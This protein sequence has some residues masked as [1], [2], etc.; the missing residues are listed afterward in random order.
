MQH[1][2]QDLTT[3][4]EDLDGQVSTLKKDKHQLLCKVRY[5]SN[6]CNEANQSALFSRKIATL[7]DEVEYWQDRAT[8]NEAALEAFVEEQSIQTFEDGRY[9]DTV[10]E[11]YMDLMCMKVGARNVETIIR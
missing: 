5:Y 8:Q 1:Q 9:V 10:R 7:K 11:L 6:R 4:K 2:L 3:Q